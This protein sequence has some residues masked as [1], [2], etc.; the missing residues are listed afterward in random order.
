MEYKDIYSD[1]YCIWEICGISITLFFKF[2]S[3]WNNLSLKVPFSVNLI[4]RRFKWEGD[5]TDSS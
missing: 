4:A 3:P 2:S 5:R 1:I